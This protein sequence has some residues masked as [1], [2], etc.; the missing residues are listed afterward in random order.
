MITDIFTSFINGFDTFY[1]SFGLTAKITKLI[2][3]LTKY[4]DYLNDFKYYMS[5][6]YFILGKPLVTYMVSVAVT[7]LVIRLILA[8]VNI[9]WP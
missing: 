8:I 6:V 3:L 2:T 7:V 9:V 4:E 1:T 5:G